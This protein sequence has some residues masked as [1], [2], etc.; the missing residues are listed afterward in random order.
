M[1]VFGAMDA[2]WRRFTKHVHKLGVKSLN[3]TIF[4]LADQP[5]DGLCLH[6]RR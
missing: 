1:R 5:K 6:F 2:D 3:T 4:V